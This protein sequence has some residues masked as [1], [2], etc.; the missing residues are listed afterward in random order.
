MRD[1]RREGLLAALGGIGLFSGSAGGWGLGAG[2]V[3]TGS[4]FFLF[5]SSACQGTTPTGCSSCVREKS[6]SV[7]APSHNSSPTGFL[8]MNDL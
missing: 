3:F 1:S 5:F 2:G 8:L 7:G 6:W 4:F